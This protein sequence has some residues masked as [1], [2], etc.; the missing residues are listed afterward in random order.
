MTDIHQFRPYG[1]YAS[2]YPYYLPSYYNNYFPRSYTRYYEPVSYVGLKKGPITVEN[3]AEPAAYKAK[4]SFII[5]IV[6]L[7]FIYGLSISF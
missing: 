3:V 5:L 6:I 4:H 1:R 2:F 7:L